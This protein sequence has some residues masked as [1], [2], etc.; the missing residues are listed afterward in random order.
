MRLVWENAKSHAFL[1]IL[2]QGSHVD[3]SAAQLHYLVMLLILFDKLIDLHCHLKA[4]LI[5]VNFLTAG[6][7]FVQ[8]AVIDL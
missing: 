7:T 2:R 4:H 6:L 8:S 3:S 5:E 1:Q